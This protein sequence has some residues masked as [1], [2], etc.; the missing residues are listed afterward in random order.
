MSLCEGA[1]FLVCTTVPVQEPPASDRHLLGLWC[2][3]K[4]LLI[5][6]VTNADPGA[7]MPIL[8]SVYMN[9]SCQSF[10]A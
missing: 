9:A 3:W 4:K 5:I 1:V 2:C 7:N 6:H 10:I 8:H